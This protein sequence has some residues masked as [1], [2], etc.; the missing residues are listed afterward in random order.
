MT[1]GECRRM[2]I[3]VQTSEQLRLKRF[4]TLDQRRQRRYPRQQTVPDIRGCDR[5][6][7]GL[8]TDCFL[9]DLGM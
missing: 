9:F 5:E 3:A 1:S 6:G 8:I 7:P 2:I 4:S